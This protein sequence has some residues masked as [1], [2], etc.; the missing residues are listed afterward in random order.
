MEFIFSVVCACI[1]HR[2]AAHWDW[3]PEWILWCFISFHFSSF[4]INLFFIECAIYFSIGL[5]RVVYNSH[6]SNAS[7]LSACIHYNER[8]AYKYIVFRFTE[9]DKVKETTHYR[10]S[11][12]CSTCFRLSMLHSIQCKVFI[13]ERRLVARIN[14]MNCNNN[15]IVI[16]LPTKFTVLRNKQFFGYFSNTHCTKPFGN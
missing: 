3:A 2:H 8:V 16:E 5:N 13:H 9:V 1:L 10:H 11:D 15:S 7:T 4:G 6:I 12:I 14:F